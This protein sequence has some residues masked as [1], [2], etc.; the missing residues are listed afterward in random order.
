MKK[1]EL[2][3]YGTVISKKN[4][5]RIIKNSRSGK[6]MLISNKTALAN[7]QDMVDQFSAQTLR[8]ENP[9]EKCKISIVIYEPNLQRRD[10]D[11]QATSI[12]DALTKSEVIKDDSIKCIKE[13][14]VRLGGIDRESPKA[15]VTI[16]EEKDEQ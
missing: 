12:L 4:T 9:I 6:P 3:Y 10:L 8:Q 2:I 14:N 1:I 5:K 11:N 13:L 15:I 7:E 16:T